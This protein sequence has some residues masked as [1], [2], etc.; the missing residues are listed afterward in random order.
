MAQ[1]ARGSTGGHGGGQFGGGGDGN[2]VFEHL[3]DVA[4]DAVGAVAAGLAQSVRRQKDA[5]LLGGPAAARATCR[6]KA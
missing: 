4:L 6:W 2:R 1:G 5:S 3:L